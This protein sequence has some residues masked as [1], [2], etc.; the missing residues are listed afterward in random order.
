M[1]AAWV[2]A[3]SAAGV[4]GDG[5]V[6]QSSAFSAGSA[7]AEPSSSSTPSA[8][9]RTRDAEA[10][11]GAAR[12]SRGAVVR[13][14]LEQWEFSTPTRRRRSIRSTPPR[15]TCPRPS[16]RRRVEPR[17][18]GPCTPPRSRRRARWSTRESWTC[19]TP[20]LTRARST[21]TLIRTPPS[22]SRTAPRGEKRTTN[23]DRL[24][25]VTKSRVPCAAGEGEEQHHHGG[26]GVAPSVRAGPEP[27]R[28]L[29]AVRRRRGA[30]PPDEA[31]VRF[32][33]RARA[34]RWS[35]WKRTA[36]EYVRPRSKYYYFYEWMRERIS[37]PALPEPIMDKSSGRE[38]DLLL[39]YPKAIRG[40]VERIP[41]RLPA[42]GRQVPGDVPNPSAVLGG[43][44]GAQGS[45]NRRPG[46]PERLGSHGA[47]A[48]VAAASTRAA[49]GSA[50]RSRCCWRT[51]RTCPTTSTPRTG[52]CSAPRATRASPR[53][54]LRV[55]S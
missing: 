20:S 40:Q 27:P 30:P 25:D 45:G 8:R 32:A 48:S 24:H 31:A 19:T 29:R 55:W 44:Q 33:K 18:R 35:G 28:L 3:S 53:R 21:A 36:P 14:E 34:P 9:G 10:R 1:V 50:R 2:S 22:K 5:T 26:G 46:A 23:A 51:P 15:R 7:A 42:R 16:R 37:F 52:P 6:D 13:A 43:G 17:G 11:A 38:L 12:L 47:W 4:D 49:T 41:R 54:R 39:R